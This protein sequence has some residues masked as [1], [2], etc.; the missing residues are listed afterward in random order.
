LADRLLLE[1]PPMEGNYLL[2]WSI[3]HSWLC[4]LVQL[5][6]NGQP[7]KANIGLVGYPNVGKSSTI[8]ALVGA[9]CVAVGSTPGKTKHFQAS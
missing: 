4:L 1:C 2:Q 7:R 9:K 8:N 5:D 6:A 3:Q